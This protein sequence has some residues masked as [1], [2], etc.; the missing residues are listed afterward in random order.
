MSGLLLAYHESI[1]KAEMLTVKGECNCQCYMFANTFQS[2]VIFLKI[3]DAMTVLIYGSL[4]WKL[5]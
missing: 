2:S 3:L 4:S 5:V 1:L